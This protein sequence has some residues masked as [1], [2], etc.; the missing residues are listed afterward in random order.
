MIRRRSYAA[1]RRGA[2]TVLQPAGVTLAST[3]TTA[4]RSKLTGWAVRAG[5]SGTQL[6]NDVVTI[7]GAGASS[8]VVYLERNSATYTLTIYLVVNGTTVATQASASGQAGTTLTASPTL[9]AGDQVWV[10]VDQN[11]GAAAA[12]SRQINTNSYMTINRP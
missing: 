11:S 3:F 12:T 2:A 6:A 5:Y 4:A 7:A 10:E 8:I 9:A 1:R